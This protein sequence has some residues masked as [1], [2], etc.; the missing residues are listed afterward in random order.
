MGQAVGPFL[1]V[2][3]VA[4]GEDLVGRRE[5]HRERVTFPGRDDFQAGPVGPDP[6]HAP[7]EEL[8]GRP[9]PGDAAGNPLVADRDIE[10]PV[11]PQ[12]DA[13]GDVVVDPVE[14]GQLRPE[15]RHQVDPRIGLPVTV[16]VAERRQERRMDDVEGPV[17]PLEA[18]DAPQLVGEGRDL[19]PSDRQDTVDRRRGRTGHIHRVGA[20]VERPV[21]RRDDRGRVEDLGRL[22]DPFDR[23][24]LGDRG[25]PWRF[26][27][28]R[29]PRPRCQD[30][31]E[32]EMA[33]MAA[34]PPCLAPNRY[35]SVS[36]SRNRPSYTRPELRKTSRPR[37]WTRNALP[38]EMPGRDLDL[39]RSGADF[40]SS[41]R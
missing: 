1:A 21:G 27:S 32:T 28:G 11:H 13:R 41:F 8:D 40:S 15:A 4:I 29:E 6:D 19:S 36:T 14:T 16:I 38:V 22:G 33:R 25:Q 9:V 5:G 30:D 18:H 35:P 23:P 20:Q 7:A 39:P 12:P 2:I 10:E 37:P 26:R 24:A 34:T 3:V 31:R 17:D